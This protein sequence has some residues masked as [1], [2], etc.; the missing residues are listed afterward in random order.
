MTKKIVDYA[1]KE[2]LKTLADN[3]VFLM[4]A[5]DGAEGP[6]IIFQQTDSL[7]WRAIN[8]PSGMS[9]VF[10]QVDCYAAGAYDAKELAAEV[11]SILDGYRGTVYYGDDSPQ[12]FVRIA[13]IT[14]QND[15]D[16]FDQTARPFLFRKSTSYLITFEQ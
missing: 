1:V 9:Q 13:G 6:F 14:L 3:Q 10:M 12:D 11:E 7:R 16:I 5:P 15:V 2:L 4:R 8:G